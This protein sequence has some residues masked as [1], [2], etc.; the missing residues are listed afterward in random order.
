MDGTYSGFTLQPWCVFGRVSAGWRMPG[1]VLIRRP[2]VWRLVLILV[3]RRRRGRLLP[4]V[5][6]LSLLL[7][8]LL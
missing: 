3:R 8:F 1:P 4:L 7:V 2:S 6:L 5:Q